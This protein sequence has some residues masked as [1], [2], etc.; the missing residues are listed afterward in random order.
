MRKLKLGANDLPQIQSWEAIQMGPQLISELTLN[1]NPIITISWGGL[2]WIPLYATSNPHG[3][4]FFSSYHCGSQFHAGEI[5]LPSASRSLWCY[6]MMNHLSFIH[7]QPGNVWVGVTF[8][9]SETWICVL[10]LLSLCMVSIEIHFIRVF[11]RSHKIKYLLQASWVVF[12]PLFHYCCPWHLFPG[13]T[14]QINNLCAS[15]CLRLCFQ[16]H[17]G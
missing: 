2:C 8:D 5:Y 10:C 1:H 12:P 6:C 17:P 7:V 11:R 3:E 15:L 13:I 16:R 4:N 9:Q 14:S